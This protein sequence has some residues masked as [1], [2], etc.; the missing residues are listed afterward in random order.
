M[1]STRTHAIALADQ[2]RQVLVAAGLSQ[3]KLNPVPSSSIVSAERRK[4][5]AQLF[6]SDEPISNLILK[7]RDERCG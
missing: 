2:V 7:E 5:L 1:N 3:P 4:T 6:A